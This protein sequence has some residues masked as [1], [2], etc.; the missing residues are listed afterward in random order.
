VRLCELASQNVYQYDG[1]IKLH[2]L[3]VD[4][5]MRTGSELRPFPLPASGQ[6]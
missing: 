1:H 2:T 3:A 6:S 4:F 5:A